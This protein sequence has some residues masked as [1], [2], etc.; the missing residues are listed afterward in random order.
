MQGIGDREV[1]LKAVRREIA[2]Q[3]GT[4]VPESD[5]AVAMAFRPPRPMCSASTGDQA[6]GIPTTAAGRAPAPP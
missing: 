6:I 4:V 2:G 1:A 5:Q 3:L